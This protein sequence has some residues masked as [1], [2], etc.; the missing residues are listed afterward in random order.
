MSKLESITLTNLRKFGPNVTIELSPGATI[1]LAPNGTGKTTVF[2]AIELGLT[3]NISRLGDNFLHAVRDSESCA[4][5][6]LNFA[7][8]TVSSR[9]SESGEVSQDGDLSTIFP[10][11]PP[12]DIPFL[13]RLTHLLDQR[14]NGWIVQ[15]EEKE[16]GS[17]LARLPLGRDGAMARTSLPAVRRSLTEQ[18]NREEE[19]LRLFEQKLIEWNGVIQA[20]DVATV[21]AVGALRPRDD[22]ARVIAQVVE[23]TESHDQLPSGLLVLPANQ[24]NLAVAHSALIEVL[25]Q[26]VE[27]TQGQI[28]G[29]AETGNLVENFGLMQA[30]LAA[31]N[32]ELKSSE[33]AL[34]GH[35][36]LR[37]DNAI[38]LQEHQ[39]GMLVAQQERIRVDQ[40]LERLVNEASA[41]QQIEHRNEALTQAGNAVAAAELQCR[42][43]RERHESNQMVRNQHSQFD[44]QLVSLDQAERR[45]RD[46]ERLVVEWELSEQC[47]RANRNEADQ[48]EEDLERLGTE[49]AE[50]RAALEEFKAI[51]LTAR[52]QYQA[53][54][55]SADAIRQAVASIA[56]HL[57]PDLED[58]PLCLE[59]HGAA[60]LQDQVAKALKAIDPSL[61]VAEQKLRAAAQDV[62]SNESVV[63][64]ALEAFQACQAALAHLEESRQ[65]FEREI[66]AF[67]IDPILASDSIPLA[68]ESLRVQLEGVAASRRSLVGRRADLALLI[69]QEEFDRARAEFEGSVH[70]LDQARIQYS[71]ALTRRDQAVATLS[72]LTAGAPLVRT[73]EELTVEKNELDLRVSD[74]NGKA[75]TLQSILETQQNQVLELSSVV[76]LTEEAIRQ[77]QSQLTSVRASWQALALEGDPLIEAAQAKGDRL[78]SAISELHGHIAEL[79]IVGIEIASWAKLNDSQIAQRFIDRLRLDRTEEAY[80]AYLK[81]AIEN[82]QRAF[83]RLS[84]LADA[85]DTLDGALKKEIA[86]VQ[87]HVRKVEPRWRA[88]LKRV[89][90][91]S[92]FHDASLKFVNTYNRDRAGVS[93]PLGKTSAPVP[94]IASEAQLTDLQLTFLLSMAM[95]HQ[96][97]PWKALLLDDPTQHHDLVHASAVFDLLR[98]YIVDHGFQVVIATHDALQAR[99]FLRKLQNDGIEAKIWSLVPTDNGVIA[100]EGQRRQSVGVAPP[101]AG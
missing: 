64:T 23:K 82:A 25:R 5:V 59:H 32:E 92:R 62:N 38:L 35:S 77:V 63:K 89:V 50:K 75:G 46:G 34:E 8:L 14:E 39:A 15:A 45:L 95:S 78:R 66:Q 73:L 84:E 80:E 26:K 22:L 13:L 65:E 47:L 48:V 43:L 20:R 69:P 21:G 72:N 29:L 36:K 88:L 98:D 58:C 85:M 61:K 53:L 19:N 6:S 40:A 87:K 90:R 1:L 55:S 10:N 94:N 70:A 56:Q 12:T 17:Q 93:V 28:A 27:R 41:R 101:T 67:R 76:R 96:W 30:R 83:N 11:I 71:D 9:I 42:T 57:P 18:K 52:A 86:N 2:E 51:E 100:E 4:E 81:G 44:S 91:E 79:E 99:Y 3:G 37:S 16:A 33:L 97:S 7:G 49:L 31:L 24:D 74:L 54:S 68:K 60:K